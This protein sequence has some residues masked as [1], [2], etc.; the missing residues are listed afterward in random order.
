MYVNCIVFAVLF[1]TP[2]FPD[3]NSQI[4]CVTC[5]LL[6]DRF[7][8]VCSIVE[9]CAAHSCMGLYSIVWYLPDWCV[10]HDIDN[11]VLYCSIFLSSVLVSSIVQYCIVQYRSGLYLSVKI[12]GSHRKIKAF[13]C[14]FLFFVNY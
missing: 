6:V 4:F 11:I 10:L 7:Y 9:Y 13:H 2:N 8:T 5:F 3:F 14:F 1:D 12:I